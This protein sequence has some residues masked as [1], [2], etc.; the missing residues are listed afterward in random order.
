MRDAGNSW[1]EIAK[2]CTILDDCPEEFLSLSL[3][4]SLSRQFFF[5]ENRLIEEGRNDEKKETNQNDRRPFLQG[6]KVP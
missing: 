2:V 6:Q 5:E 4:P 1:A 3:S